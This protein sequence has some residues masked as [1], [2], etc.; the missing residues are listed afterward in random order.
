[1]IAPPTAPIF[2]PTSTAE[3]QRA[4]RAAARV[5]PAAGG[6]AVAGWA[7]GT[8]VARWALQIS[9]YVDIGYRKNEHMN[10]H[11]YI[12]IYI[13]VYIYIGIYI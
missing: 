10:M 7:T 6:A 2:Q 12:I 8:G 4:A 13:Y 5:L 11:L 9:R 1:V 3:D